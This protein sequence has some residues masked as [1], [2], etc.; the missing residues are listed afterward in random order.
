VSDRFGLGWR[1]ELAAELHLR[2]D[3]LDLVEVIADDWMF[4]PAREQRALRALAEQVPLTL[5]G[6]SL[7]LCSAAPVDERRLA[8]FARL[9]DRVRP[10]AWSEHLAFVRGGGTEIGHLAAPPRTDA[11]L[12]GLARNVARA[13]A[14][15]GSPPQLENV[16]TLVEPAGSEHAETEWL[17]RAQ[18]AAGAPLL[19]DLHNLYANARNFGFDAVAALDRLPW[20]RVQAVHIA[21][22]RAWRPDEPG[23]RGAR[24]LDDHRHAVPDA[25]YDLLLE[26]GRRAP[27]P[28][29]VVLER[30]GNYPSVDDLLAELDRA[31]AAL[32]SGRSAPLRA[33]QPVAVPSA[34]SAGPLVDARRLEALLARAHTEPRVRE[35]LLADADAAFAAEGLR[36]SPTPLDEEGLRLAARSFAAKRAARPKPAPRVEWWRRWSGRA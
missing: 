26:A 3:R 9:V 22:G 6:V 7:G 25:V 2:L 21:G 4:R 29:D 19:L 30:D 1:P 18:A 13:R 36:P 16:A 23:V 35:A 27:R 5:H 14:A 12:D 11:T 8:A 15:V 33:S 31:R 24:W 28:L 32:A 34:R 20:E 10:A 17:P